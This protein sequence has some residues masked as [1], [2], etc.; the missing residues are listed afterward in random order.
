MVNNFNIVNGFINDRYRDEKT[1]HEE[2]IKKVSAF[3]KEECNSLLEYLKKNLRFD[4]PLGSDP[5]QAII[6]LNECKVVIQERLAKI[7]SEQSIEG[8]IQYL[9][10]VNSGNIQDE[11]VELE[12]IEEQRRNID[13]LKTLNNKLSS[14]PD[15]ISNFIKLNSNYYQDDIRYHVL[16]YLI[17]LKHVIKFYIN[18]KEKGF[19]NEGKLISISALD[20]YK[21]KK[22][23]FDNKVKE[24][25]LDIKL[26][27]E[28]EK[29]IEDI[30]KNDY[31]N[32]NY[33][34]L[35]NIINILNSHYDRI[36]SIAEDKEEDL[37][38]ISIN[39]DE[40][41]ATTFVDTSNTSNISNKYITFPFDK[42]TKKLSLLFSNYIVNNSNINIIRN[43]RLYK[44]NNL[45][46]KNLINSFNVALINTKNSNNHDHSFKEQIKDIDPISIIRSKNSL[47]KLINNLNYISSQQ[48]YKL[49]T[50]STP[51]DLSKNIQ[52][53]K[54][55]SKVLQ[56]IYHLFSNYHNFNKLTD[57]VK[58]ETDIK[59]LKK[60]IIQILKKYKDN[61]DKKN[62]KLLDMIKDQNKIIFPELSDNYKITEKTQF[63]YHDFLLEVNPE[64][65]VFT[66]LQ[67]WDKRENELKNIE[68][69][70]TFF[71]IKKEDIDNHEVY[72]STKKEEIMEFCKT[73]NERILDFS[74]LIKPKLRYDEFNMILKTGNIR[75]IRHTIESEVKLLSFYPYLG[76]INNGTLICEDANAILNLLSR[77]DF[78]NNSLKPAYEIYNQIYD[79]NRIVYSVRYHDKKKNRIEK[80]K[81]LISF[82]ENEL[83]KDKFKGKK[84]VS[85]KNALSTINEYDDRS[86]EIDY[87]EESQKNLGQ[88]SFRKDSL[89]VRSNMHTVS[90]KVDIGFVDQFGTSSLDIDKLFNNNFRTQTANEFYKKINKKS[91]PI[92]FSRS[93]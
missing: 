37:F 26:F 38:S 84:V 76:D 13:H 24:F 1:A 77:S 22:Y 87:A 32:N 4:C 67:Y 73:I 41:G 20:L 8:I 36:V 75:L 55:D 54:F 10:K 92:E 89:Y 3:N 48:K 44:N 12:P 79:L 59:K 80:K 33:E 23:K 39:Q 70:V 34:I 61:E 19:N 49:A 69:Y 56:N 17:D 35:L 14:L 42:F 66:G 2:L 93:L 72:S 47:E 85:F 16:K 28:L 5:N 51:L 64:K 15:K 45:F 29:T 78:L 6:Y 40:I 83:N 62:I 82:L 81:S 46:I 25:N 53:I 18:K 27:E 63:N 60:K 86:T 74:I 68:G 58:K 71:P 7:Q 21:N 52:F 65:K 11:I 9:Y 50:D 90:Q 88:G 31:S 57:K 30:I 43:Y 91:L